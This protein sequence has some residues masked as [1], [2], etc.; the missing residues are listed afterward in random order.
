M[1]RWEILWGESWVNITMMLADAPQ[2]IR[3]QAPGESDKTEDEFLE[4]LA[5]KI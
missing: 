5:K 3:E 4:E 2:Y 1:S